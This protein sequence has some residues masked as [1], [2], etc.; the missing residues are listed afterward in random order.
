MATGILPGQRP[1]E[2]PQEEQARFAREE[3]EYRQQQMAELT[4]AY[5][6]NPEGSARRYMVEQRM[7]DLGIAAPVNVS[8]PSTP[9][10]QWQGPLP[11]SQWQ[12]PVQTIYDPQI[13]AQTPAVEPKAPPRSIITAR[14]DPATG[15]KVF[16]NETVDMS[17]PGAAERVS[18]LQEAYSNAANE[19]RKQAM[20]DQAG[21]ARGTGFQGQLQAGDRGFNPDLA[22]NVRQGNFM[23]NEDWKPTGRGNV[24]QPNMAPVGEALTPEAWKDMSFGAQEEWKRQTQDYIGAETAQLGT[25]I[26]R[27]KLRRMKDPMIEVN[28]NMA[29]YNYVADKIRNRVDVQMSA[30]SKLA[31]VISAAAKEGKQLSPEQQ[32][33]LLERFTVEEVNLRVGPTMDQVMRSNPAVAAASLRAGSYGTY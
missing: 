23:I 2:S 10:Y 9:A 32:A 8:A 27:E 1:P 3:E 30:K 25:D 17:E 6:E 28:E 11:P 7:R 24:S 29:M 18:S 22:P 31:A 15:K 20:S 12:G 16:T 21:L 33:E 26:Q 13:A 5:N 4:Q 14:I 19:W